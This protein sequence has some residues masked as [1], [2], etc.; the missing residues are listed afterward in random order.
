M[1]KKAA[2]APKKTIYRNCYIRASAKNSD[3]DQRATIAATGPMTGKHAKTIVETGK[4]GSAEVLLRMLKTMYA[5]ELLVVAELQCLGDDKPSVMAVLEKVQAR[6]LTVFEAATKRKFTG[7]LD[8]PAAGMALD[9]YFRGRSLSTMKAKRAGKEG[10]AKRY[11]DLHAGRVPLD[12]AVDR[13]NKAVRRGAKMD[14]AI[15]AVNKGYSEYL[16]YRT[17]RKLVTDKKLPGEVLELPAGR[18]RTK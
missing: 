17:W 16:P 12:I 5:G 9:E 14:E 18:R 4:K 10:A 3:S 8:G 13:W 6:G 15:A 7:A 1:A 2:Q 11:Q